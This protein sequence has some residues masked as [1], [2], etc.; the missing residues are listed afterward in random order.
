MTSQKLNILIV[1]DEEEITE[2]LSFIVKSCIPCNVFIATNGQEAIDSISKDAIKLVICDYNMPNL[3]GGDVYNYVQNFAPNCKYVM[4]SSDSPEKYEAFLDRSSFFGQIIKPNLVNGTKAILE[5][6][7]QETPG[8]LDTINDD[9]TPIAVS[10]LFSLSVLPSDVFLKLSENRFIKVFNKDATFEETDLIRY[11]QNGT[12]KLYAF[13]ISTNLYIDRI[14]DNIQKITQTITPENRTDVALQVQFLLASSFREYGLQET[15]IPMVEYHLKETLDICKSN[16]NLK[17]LLSKLLRS[18]DS[19]LSKHSFMLAAISV[20]IAEKLDWSS[21]TTTQ[22]LTVASLFH[23]IYLK[24][25]YFDENRLLF[26][27]NH[28]EDFLSH[29]Q[30]AA[31][32]LNKMPNILP[33]TSRIILEHHEIG[34]TLGIPRGIPISKTTPLT[35]LFTF[36]HFVVDLLLEKDKDHAIDMNEFYEKLERICEGSDKYKKLVRLFRELK[37]L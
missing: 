26:E 23:D 18:K 8:I 3:N 13:N 21:S 14:R 24:D 28:N 20:S 31:D 37:I 15:L 2:I 30:K 22:K 19:Y 33:D 6:F 16:K 1:D 27:V 12:E 25:S 32:L 36:S 34:E 29:P 35:Q 7:K 4:C 10:L 9:Y 17:L 5:K 11:T